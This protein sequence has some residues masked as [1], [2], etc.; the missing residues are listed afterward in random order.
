MTNEQAW[1]RVLFGRRERIRQA[2]ADRTLVTPREVYKSLGFP[3][4]RYDTRAAEAICG[5]LASLGFTLQGNGDWQKGD[6]R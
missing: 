3:S 2:L 4:E 1:E 6:S 5:A